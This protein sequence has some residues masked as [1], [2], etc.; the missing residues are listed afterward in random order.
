MGRV[1]RLRTERRPCVRPSGGLERVRGSTAL[2]VE[3]RG[4]GRDG[5]GG[6]AEVY[7]SVKERRGGHG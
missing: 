4:E 3:V 2:F 6:R 1:D 5:H 7:G